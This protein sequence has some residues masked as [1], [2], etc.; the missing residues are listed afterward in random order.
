MRAWEVNKVAVYYGPQG[1]PRLARTLLGFVN[2]DTHDE[3]CTLAVTHW[4]H[5]L[6]GL[7]IQGVWSEARAEWARTQAV[8]R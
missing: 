7:E 3:A 1:Q 8:N 4:P 5:D 2:A 6:N